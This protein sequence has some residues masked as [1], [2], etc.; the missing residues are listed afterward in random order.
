MSPGG[1]CSA[2]HPRCAGR[3]STR[4]RPCR[5]RHPIPR[6]PDRATRRIVAQIEDHPE[7]LVAGLL[8]Q[9]LHRVV[10]ADIGLLVEAGDADIAD[11]VALEMRAHRLDL[12]HRA[13]QLDVEGVLSLA[14]DRQL[15]FAADRPRIFSTASGR[16][17]PCTGSPSRWVIRSPGFSPARAAGRVVDR[18]DHLDEAVLHRHLDPE[19]AELAAGLHLH[20][21]E[22]LRVQIVRMRIE[23]GQHAVDRPRSGSRR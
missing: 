23:R 19:P 6:P 3:G 22:V 1:R 7:Q 12:D 15:D 8:L 16:V 21:V 20:V 10:E 13:G 2:G 9:V 14:P 5:E 11:L 4:S 18:R 17:I